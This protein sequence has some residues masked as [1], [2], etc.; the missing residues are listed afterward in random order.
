MEI[1]ALFTIFKNNVAACA[2][3]NTINMFEIFNC[4]WLPRF[5]S[6]AC[7]VNVAAFNKLPAGVASKPEKSGRFGFSPVDYFSEIV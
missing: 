7:G 3:N 5:G 4:I 2:A 6:F 1:F